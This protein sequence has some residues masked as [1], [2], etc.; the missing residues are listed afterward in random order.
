MS[1]SRFEHMCVCMSGF[2]GMWRAWRGRHPELSVWWAQKEGKEC[3]STG[4]QSQPHSG[5]QTG[6]AGECVSCGTRL[7]LYLSI[8]WHLCVYVCV[9]CRFLMY[10]VNWRRCSCTGFS[11]PRLCAT[12]KQHPVL[13]A[14]TTV[15]TAWP[16]HGMMHLFLLSAG[17]W[18]GTIPWFS[19]TSEPGLDPHQEISTAMHSSNIMQPCASVMIRH[20]LY[21]HVYLMKYNVNQLSR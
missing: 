9:V 20:L 19:T 3:N 2:P 13:L 8:S 12:V 21:V 4:V 11:S 6:S 15:G 7:L 5:C 16:K 18:S 1:C 14:M 10:L 17:G